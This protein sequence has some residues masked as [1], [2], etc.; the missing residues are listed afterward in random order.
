MPLPI[1][2]NKPGR[3]AWIGVAGA[4]VTANAT[5]ITALAS[6]GETV[7]GAYITQVICTGAVTIARG[8]NTVFQS[9][10]GGIHVNFKAAGMNLPN[11]PDA[12]IVVTT[13][14]AATTCYIELQKKSK[15]TSN[16]Y[17]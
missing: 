9:A 3:T 15:L 10:T 16:E 8:S 12:D 14:A 5:T 11:Y 1:F 4:A 13:G 6:P 17:G 7:T 2:N